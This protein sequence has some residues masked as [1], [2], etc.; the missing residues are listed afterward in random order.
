MK[1][2]PI[3]LLGTGRCGSTLVQR[4]LNS[5]PEVLILGEHNGFLI[6]LAEAYFSLTSTPNVR[7]W[8]FNP[9]FDTNEMIAAARDPKFF[10]AWLNSFTIKRVQHNFRRLIA[11]VLAEE[12]DLDQV[13]WGFKEIRYGENDRVLPMLLELY[14]EA[15]Y[16]FIFRNVMDTIKSMLTAWRPNLSDRLENGKISRKEISKIIMEFA[17]RWATQNENLLD[18]ADKHSGNSFIVKYE[19]LFENGND[20]VARLFSFIEISRPGKV[21]K[22]LMS[23]TGA[24]SHKSHGETMGLWLKE[25]Q[26]RI[27]ERVA[28]VRERL[29][30]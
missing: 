30:Y 5:S 25:E 29:G 1:T 26:D 23:K 17:N 15:S 13:R 10:S 8:I 22:V 3:F 28:K 18:F 14:P 27:F 9:G 24:T 4:I 19:V 20:V 11:G 12:I 21:K 16:I 7:K 2:K 6:S